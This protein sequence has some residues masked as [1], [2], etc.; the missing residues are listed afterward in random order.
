MVVVVKV[1]NCAKVG[2]MFEGVRGYEYCFWCLCLV[3]VVLFGVK[4]SMVLGL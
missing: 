2:V 1:W 4:G 3:F